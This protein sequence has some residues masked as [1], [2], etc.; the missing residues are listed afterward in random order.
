MIIDL[1]IRPGARR[2][3]AETVKLAL[4]ALCRVG[5]RLLGALARLPRTSRCNGLA[6]LFT[7][8]AASRIAL[9]LLIYFGTVNL[10]RALGEFSATPIWHSRLCAGVIALGLFRAYAT[11]VFVAQ[12]SPSKGH[13]S[14]VAWPSKWRIFTKLIMPQMWRMPCGLGNLS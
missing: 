7:W 1:R 13:R 12:S 2:W 3:R 5:A 4:S 9:V 8:C 6:V 11:E 14:R 10:M